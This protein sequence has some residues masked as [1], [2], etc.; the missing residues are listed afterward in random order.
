MS[1]RRWWTL[2]AIL[3]T[4]SVTGHSIPAQAPAFS[5]QAPSRSNPSHIPLLEAP[6]ESASAESLLDGRLR[7]LPAVQHQQMQKLAREI[8][9]NPK[10]FGFENISEHLKALRAQKAGPKLDD[11]A[12][13]ERI[14]QILKSMGPLIQQETGKNL[15]V[16]DGLFQNLVKQQ[17]QKHGPDPEPGRTSPRH[18]PPGAQRSR[19]RESAAQPSH[20]PVDPAPLPAGQDGRQTAVWAR[21]LAEMAERIKPGPAITNSPA[22]KRMMERLNRYKQAGGPFQ[23]FDTPD[24]LLGRLGLDGR[25]GQLFSPERWSFR[26]RLPTPALPNM[27]R[28]LP[29][30]GHEGGGWSLGQADSLPEAPSAGVWRG[31][32]WAVLLAVLGGGLWLV[33]ARRKLAWAEA[34]TAGAWSLGPWPVLPG[35]VRSPADLVRAF[36]YLSLLVLGVEARNWNHRRIAAALADAHAGEERRRAAFGLA[37]VYEH[38]RYAPAGQPISAEALSTARHNLCVLAGAP[39]A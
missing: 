14:Q 19:P 29:S 20:A 23:S 4:W 25:F 3:A 12:S 22:W 35:Q 28:W 31:L 30:L 11:R 26:A 32:L 13:V 36:E 8:L 7:N 38:A 9:A 39:T 34:E 18:G 6:A 27:S 5:A 37:T 10:K 2:A 1:H 33:L 15:D 16:N 24:S 21:R 17:A